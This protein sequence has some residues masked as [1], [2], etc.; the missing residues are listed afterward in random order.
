MIELVRE[1]NPTPRAED[2]AVRAGTAIRTVFRHFRDMEGLYREIAHAIQTQSKSMLD[3]AVEGASWREQLDDL[4][5]KRIALY[6]KLRP[7]RES[8][9]AIRH[10]SAFLRADHARFVALG[11]S[12]LRRILPD[13]LARDP[14]RI[15]AIDVW[16]SFEVWLRLR[17]DQKLSVKKA[18]TVVKTTAALIT[19]ER[20][21]SR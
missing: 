10:R 5:D 18:A 21:R 2:V 12:T 1:G 13:T 17:R 7:I 9:D 16:L 3:A 20:G 8:A 14:V 15:E 19:A 11:R 4:I 6:E